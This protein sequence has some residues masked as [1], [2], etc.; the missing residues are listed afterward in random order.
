MKKNLYIESMNK[1]Y[2]RWQIIITKIILI[3]NT[4]YTCS[5]LWLKDLISI[6]LIKK[7]LIFLL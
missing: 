5:D 1:Y 2:K 6:L 7:Y 4:F 3:S